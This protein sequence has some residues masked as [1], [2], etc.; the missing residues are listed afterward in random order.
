MG[1]T[2][3]AVVKQ[4]NLPLKTCAVFLLHWIL[5]WAHIVNNFWK[6][7]PRYFASEKISSSAPWTKDCISA[8]KQKLTQVSNKQTRSNLN[9]A[10]LKRAI[11]FIQRRSHIN[12][13]LK[14]Q[15]RG[16]NSNSLLKIY[17]KLLHEGYPPLLSLCHMMKL[18]YSRISVS[19]VCT[20]IYNL[21]KIICRIHLYISLQ[22]HQS[23]LSSSPIFSQLS[24]A[25]MM[26]M[27]ISSCNSPTC[28]LPRSYHRQWRRSRAKNQP[29]EGALAAT[30][31]V[32]HSAERPCSVPEEPT[33]LPSPWPVCSPKTM[34]SAPS[35][36]AACISATP[37]WFNSQFQ[38]IPS[39]CHKQNDSE[40]LKNVKK[41]EFSP[42]NGSSLHRWSGHPPSSVPWSVLE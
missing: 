32:M 37:R 34:N 24:T 25:I 16:L 42:V 30:Q 28:H 19:I 5:I 35:V 14:E 39:S 41:R 10:R 18:L 9:S 21:R 29:T 33:S 27:F 3:D 4:Q 17:V 38:S 11:F 31:T 36:C 1:N 12:T 20:Y 8:V 22:L 40:N 13:I 7:S 15:L 26:F 23:L 6:P 2:I